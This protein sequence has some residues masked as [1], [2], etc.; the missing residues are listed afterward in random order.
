M[1]HKKCAVFSYCY[2]CE[3]IAENE[4]IKTLLFL[5]TLF[6]TTETVDRLQ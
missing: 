6:F 1:I 4:V 5:F 2:K 3:F